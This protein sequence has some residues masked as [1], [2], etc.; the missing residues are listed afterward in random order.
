MWLVKAAN[1]QTF[2]E[3]FEVK[4][5]GTSIALRGQGVVVGLHK[6]HLVDQVGGVYLESE[7]QR[8]GPGPCLSPLDIDAGQNVKGS[9]Q[10]QYTI[11]FTLSWGPLHFDLNSDDANNVRMRQFQG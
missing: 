1:S 6:F 10:M 7:G 3:S 9:P 2:G 4:G 8:S 5:G 11:S